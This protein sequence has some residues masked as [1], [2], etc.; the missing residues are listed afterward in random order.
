MRFVSSHPL[1][2]LNTFLPSFDVCIFKQSKLNTMSS[3]I[4]N[5]H[6]HALLGKSNTSSHLKSLSSS[7]QSSTKWNNRVRSCKQ[8][9][10]ILS[11]AGALWLNQL[12]VLCTVHIWYRCITIASLPSSHCTIVWHGVVWCR[13]SYF[14]LLPLL[15]FDENTKEQISSRDSMDWLLY[16][17]LFR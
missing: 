10:G 17:K 14:H 9:R 4:Y 16:I 15:K 6:D 7:S 11:T 3:H 1:A 5:H 8:S 12:L 2:K 13:F